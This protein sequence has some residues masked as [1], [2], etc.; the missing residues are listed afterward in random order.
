MVK[1]K[2]RNLKQYKQGN[3]EKVL[4]EMQKDI[5]DFYTL[6]NHENI[7]PRRARMVCASEPPRIEFTIEI[8][9]DIENI[10]SVVNGCASDIARLGFMEDIKNIKEELDFE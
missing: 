1:G 2:L 3:E 7:T 9:S 8:E 10:S 5:N 4:K 6:R